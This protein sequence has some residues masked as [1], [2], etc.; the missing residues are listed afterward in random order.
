MDLTEILSEVIL[1]LLLRGFVSLQRNPLQEGQI[2]MYELVK[3][4]QYNPIPHRLCV[5]HRISRHFQRP[6]GG[7]EKSQ[8]S[9]FWGIQHGKQCIREGQRDQL[10]EVKKWL[11]NSRKRMIVTAVIRHYIETVIAHARALL[12]G[13]SE[14]PRNHHS[15]LALPG[16]QT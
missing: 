16:K 4:I 14:F 13:M 10:E 9:L 2:E 12:F 3:L 6:H 15:T 1:L 8:K 7:H 11:S 5:S